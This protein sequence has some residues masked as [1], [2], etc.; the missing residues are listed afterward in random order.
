M[1]SPSRTPHH[2]AHGSHMPHHEE[3]V[4]QTP[5]RSAR[6]PT[7]QVENGTGTPSRRGIPGRTPAHRDVCDFSF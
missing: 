5:R 1:S 4:R 2:E 6:T 3:S 7:Q